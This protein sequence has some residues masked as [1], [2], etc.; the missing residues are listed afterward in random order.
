MA[1]R[2]TFPLF[3]SRNG[4]KSFGRLSTRDAQIRPPIGMGIVGVGF[5]QPGRGT[6]HLGQNRRNRIHAGNR[7]EYFQPA[8]PRASGRPGPSGNRFICIPNSSR[9]LATRGVDFHCLLSLYPDHPMG[10]LC[11]RND[12]FSHG[13]LQHHGKRPLAEWVLFRHRRLGFH[14]R[15]I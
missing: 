8:W 15:H 3:S 13:P 2:K 11:H 12:R 10:W 1:S 9:R 6:A 14:L 7:R 4:P 5:N